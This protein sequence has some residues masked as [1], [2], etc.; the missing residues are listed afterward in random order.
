MKYVKFIIN[1]FKGIDGKMELNLT[2]MPN[3]NI[4]TLVGLNES[5]KTS[6]LEAI[7]LLQNRRPDQK[8]HEMIHKSKKGNFNDS[9][10]VEAV[11]ELND[12][13]E[14]RIEEYCKGNA[15]FILTE[16]IKEIKICKKY[17]FKDSRFTNFKSIWTLP[18]TGRKARGKKIVDLY[19]NYRDDWSKVVEFIEKNFPKIL[20]YQ[21]FLFKF[22]Q[23]IYLEDLSNLS[24]EE[25]EYRK[26]LQDVL[27]SFVN[28]LTIEK[29]ILE[30]LKSDNKEDKES[31]D[32]LLGDV[33]Q[34][35][36]DTIFSSWGEVFKKD[37]K[38]IELKYD[39]DNEKGHYIQLK[40]K[41]GKARYF[42][43]ERSLG[44]RWFFSFLLFTEFRK[45]RK[46][47]FGETLFL[48][49]EP[50]N[51]LHQKSQTK[52]LSM[53]E[54]LSQNCK[55]IYS[56][57]SQ[58]LINP[59]YLSGTYIVK[60]SAINY[61]E[62]DNFSQNETKIS[63][64]PYKNFVSRYP[65]ETDHFK[66]IL[67]A[68]DY[69]PSNLELVKNIV[70]LEGKNDYYT[71]KYFQ[72]TIFE[73]YHFNFYPGAGV[74][75]YENLL[76]L[77]LAWRR[78]LIA[79]FDADKQGERA[80]NKYIKT[81]SAELNDRIFIL[82]NIDAEWTNLV[83]EDLFTESDKI[84]IIQTAFPEENTYS[85]SKFNTAIQDLYIKGEKIKLSNLTINNFKKIFEFIKDKI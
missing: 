16:K 1:N 73:N 34:K 27:D 78:D 65:K 64:M 35:L 38:E 25:K 76:R 42:I 47:D 24:N 32:S 75:K 48:L 70:C 39:R 54:K 84:T 85:K 56:T 23:K 13:D 66:P 9:I 8:A 4:F 12:E 17:I 20:Y 31:L 71:M 22:P 43:E 63:A 10:S 11:L 7:D 49:D 29:H 80:K 30:R 61:E 26:V 68:I 62:E 41:Q 45:A 81:I 53:F 2:P 19:S 28:G 36:T 50:A 40:I 14:R 33:A 77:Y 52:L 58:H 44:F 15:N 37:N 74:D 6:I 18:L 57:H 59:K 21:D 67:D 69:V 55:V 46:E 5:G 72:E 83:T 79:I 3:T 60:N 82:S 51:N